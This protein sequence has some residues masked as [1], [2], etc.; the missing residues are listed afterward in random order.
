MLIANIQLV[1]T[2]PTHCLRQPCTYGMYS[3]CTVLQYAFLTCTPSLLTVRI[4]ET[5]P[6]RQVAQEKSQWQ[7]SADQ[8]R[9]MT[10]TVK[11]K[12]LQPANYKDWFHDL[13]HLEESHA[14]QQLIQTW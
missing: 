14:R 3:I 10:Y 13:L 8:G 12:D 7:R 4:R 11:P 1:F 9:A 6:V 2:V 5:K